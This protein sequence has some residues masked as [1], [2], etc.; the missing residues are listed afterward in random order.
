M[1]GRDLMNE[2]IQW[3]RQCSVIF[4]EFV[5]NG[6]T[7]INDYSLEELDSPKHRIAFSYTK[8]IDEADTESNG[9]IKIYGLTKETFERIGQAMKTEVELLCGFRYSKTTQLQRLFKAVVVDK[10]FEYETSGSL[11][12]FKVLGDFINSSVVSGKSSENKGSSK[13]VLSKPPKTPMLTVLKD[14]A[15]LHGYTNAGLNV[16]TTNEN[17]NSY[18]FNYKGRVVDFSQ[19]LS[20]L[21]YP[22]GV[23]FYGT[24]REA[25]IQFCSDWGL[26]WSINQTNNQMIFRFKEVYF[27]RHLRLATESK[28]SEAISG[29]VLR[30]ENKSPVYE[31][32]KPDVNADLK[33]LLKKSVAVYL[34]PMTGLKG[35]PK[36]TTRTSDKSYDSVVETKNKSETQTGNYETKVNS[37]GEKVAVEKDKTETK[38]S[39]VS[40]KLRELTIE[41]VINPLIEPQSYVRLDAKFDHED[42]N[43][44]YRVR[45]V[46]I[47]GDTH[48]EEWDMR[49]GIDGE[50]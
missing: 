43:G 38:K 12:V 40:K 16:S 31:E 29:A 2:D 17:S 14:L 15:K 20:K 48:G 24:P 5:S 8:S 37:K 22:V 9:E 23:V 28:S 21:V 19:Y 26:T 13:I 35:S 47:A 3:E 44:E 41:C 46:E 10:T 34:S 33:T 32:Y 42:V 11:S 6:R 1:F 4:T 36:I 45:T 27:T 25:L 49:L 7:Q 50:F 39:N 30:A 18:A